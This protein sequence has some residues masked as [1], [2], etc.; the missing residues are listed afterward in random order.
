MDH[1]AFQT[2]D[3]FHAWLASYGLPFD[4][5]ADYVDSDSDGMNNFQEY[6]AGTN[7]TNASSM[8]RISSA[9]MIF[10]TQFVV[11]W[12]GVSNRLYDVTRATNLAVGAAAF[13]SSATNLVGTPPENIW[14]DSVNNAAT[15][16]FYRIKVH[17]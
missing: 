3:A 6:V 7:P 10:S 1:F 8:F 9:Q 12:S 13:L 16:A 11:H 4:G 5:S 15:P 17:Q 14:T 2:L